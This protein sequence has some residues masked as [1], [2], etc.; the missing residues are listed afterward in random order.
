[1][2]HAAAVQPKP[3][4]TFSGQVSLSNLHDDRYWELAQRVVAGPQFA[5]SPLL[6]RFLLYVVAET[7]EGR[8]DEITEHQIGVQVFDRS[9]DYRTLEDNIVRSYA[10]QLRKRLAEHFADRGSAEKVRIDIPVGGY[11]PVFLPMADNSEKKEPEG[12]SIHGRDAAPSGALHVAGDALSASRWLAA[13]GRLRMVLLIAAYSAVLVGVTWLVAAHVAA[14]RKSD[15]P[16]RILWR[17]IFG[18]AANSYIVPSDAGFNLLEDL[19]REPQ[20]LAQYIAGSYEN[21]P[22]GGVDAHS[23]EDLHTQQLT[24]FVDL[25]IARALAH[26]AEDDPQRVLIRFPR[27]LRL[28]DL[29]DANAVIIG[30]LGSNPWAAMVEA[31][32]NFRIVYQPGMSGAEIVNQRP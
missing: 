29:K 31:S 15:E 8:G 10:R 19:S 7:L 17:T 24:P 16:A 9:P 22:L 4:L 20:P 21:L 1:M 6:S 30:S 2:E 25:Q 23:A 26:L 11:V 32:A 28:D 14:P 18:G 3:R 5:R 27:D 13:I 12:L